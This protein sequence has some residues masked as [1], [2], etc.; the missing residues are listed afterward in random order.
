MNKSVESRLKGTQ[1]SHFFQEFFTNSAYFPLAN[2]ILELLLNDPLDYLLEPDPYFILFAAVIQ[3]WVI[4]NWHYH[5]KARPLIG[6]FIGPLIYTLIEFTLEGGDF[7]ASPNHVAYWFFSAGIGLAQQLRLMLPSRFASALILLENLLRTSILLVMYTILEFITDDYASLV[8]FLASATHRFVVITIP[9]IGLIIGF[10][11]IN[12]ERYLAMLQDTAK[13]LKKYSEWLLGRDLLAQAVSDPR[14][15]SLRRQQRCMLFMDIRGFTAWSEQQDPEQVVALMNEYYEVAEPVWKA[16][17]AIKVKFTA[18]EIMLVFTDSATAMAAA[19]KLREDSGRLLQEHGLSAGIGLHAGAVVE[20][21]MGSGDYKGY[22]L[23]GDSVN[24]AK[25][26]C[27]NAS[28]G[29]ILVSQQVMDEV[30]K[31]NLQAIS[32]RMKVK[33]KSDALTVHAIT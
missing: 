28:G 13:Q 26:L 21:M 20:G 33:G 18:D 14:V 1:S 2:I 16:H 23:L 11:H 24:T 10:A 9:L 12:A 22:D 3:A 5:D 30:G 27:D 29:E 4:S 8:E 32:R 31:G 15:L 19:R 25:R 17:N 6:N 7:F